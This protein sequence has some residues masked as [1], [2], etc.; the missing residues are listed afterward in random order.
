MLMKML[1][2]VSIYRGIPFNYDSYDNF[3]RFIIMN[4]EQNLSLESDKEK[5]L[6]KIVSE[7]ALLIS[8]N[9]EYK[10]KFKNVI[11]VLKSMTF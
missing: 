11:D 3:K 10:I 9:S 1:E 6:Y 5:D 2:G 4:F 7:V 8:Q